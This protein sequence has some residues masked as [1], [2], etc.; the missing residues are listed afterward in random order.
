MA[1]SNYP[2]STYRRDVL[3]ARVHV[4]D[5]SHFALDMAADEIAV[6]VRDFVGHGR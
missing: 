1:Q 4:L 2:A 3:G 6:L 5:A